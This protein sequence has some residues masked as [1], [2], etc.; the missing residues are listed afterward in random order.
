MTS[1]ASAPR[2][3]ALGAVAGTAVIASAPWV[4]VR[5]QAKVIRLAHHVSL[6]SEQHGPDEEQQHHFLGPEHRQAERVAVD[7]LHQRERAE[8]RE[9]GEAAPLRGAHQRAGGAND[10]GVVPRPVRAT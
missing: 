7:H 9:A 8:R 6:Q 5:A 2:R 3:A 1:P 10:H 4:G